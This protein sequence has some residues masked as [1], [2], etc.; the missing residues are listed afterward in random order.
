LWQLEVE[1]AI[2]IAEDEDS[3]D[4]SDQNTA[5]SPALDASDSE[6]DAPIPLLRRTA[7]GAK[8]TFAFAVPS[9]ASSSPPVSPARPRAGKRPKG[10]PD[11]PTPNPSPQKQ[12]I[13]K[14]QAGSDVPA[15]PPPTFARQHLPSTSGATRD[16]FFGS[17][18]RRHAH[19]GYGTDSESERDG[20]DALHEGDADEFLWGPED[21][22]PVPPESQLSQSSSPF[23]DFSILVGT[24]A[25]DSTPL[26]DEDDHSVVDDLPALQDVSCSE[27]DGDDDESDADDSG[28]IPDSEDVN[29]SDD[30]LT[31]T[32]A[33]GTHAPH[34]P[35]QP[36]PPAKPAGAGK[37][38]VTAYFKVETAEEKAVRLEK[39]AREYREHA[40][41]VRLREVDTIRK[42]NAKARADGNERMRR[43]RHRVR[44]AKIADGYVPG[45]KRVSTAVI[46]VLI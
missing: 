10:H 4:Q 34:A 14:R 19:G 13:F 35:T 28:P 40:E 8:F 36:S 2:A 15:P 29:K 30:Q 20:G 5:T 9:P 1:R 22:A 16:V 46:Q 43:Y 37:A 44:E 26:M 17:V 11:A 42:K 7:R 41:E 24:V 3:D 31:V 39:D 25:S 21:D 45:R 38:K 33:E 32:P 18:T 6:S 27:D 23:Q 12:R